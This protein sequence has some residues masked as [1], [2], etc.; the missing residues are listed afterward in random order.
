MVT[1]TARRRDWAAEVLR[2]GRRREGS[3]RAC[4]AREGPRD[5][6]APLGSR[7]WRRGKRGERMPERGR[8]GEFVF[9]YKETPFPPTERRRYFRAWICLPHWN[10]EKINGGGECIFF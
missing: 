9:N 6:P 4:S 2:H 8:A 10:L 1:S 7:G 3:T 5:H